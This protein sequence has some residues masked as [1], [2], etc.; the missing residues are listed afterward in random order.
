[1]LTFGVSNTLSSRP[2]LRLI[3]IVRVDSKA[4][5]WLGPDWA[6]PGLQ[7][8]RAACNGPTRAQYMPIEFY[9]WADWLWW[10]G[11]FCTIFYIV[12]ESKVKRLNACVVNH[13]AGSW[14]VKKRGQ[15]TMNHKTCDRTISLAAEPIKLIKRLQLNH[16]RT[17]QPSSPTIKHKS[18]D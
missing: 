3:P 14:K 13:A 17:A 11:L 5:V 6:C 1:M 2:I 8:E 16:Y 10:F 12:H 7:L 4:F 18:M 9:F 15:R